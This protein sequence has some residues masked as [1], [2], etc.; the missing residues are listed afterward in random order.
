M[1]LRPRNILLIM[2]WYEQRLHRGVAE[3]AR[4]HRWSLEVSGAHSFWLPEHLNF[5]G[6][7]CLDEA[8]P[9][10][11]KFLVHVQQPTVDLSDWYEGETQRPRVVQDN[12]QIGRLVAE[13]FLE[14]GFQ[15]FAFLRNHDLWHERQRE[16]G[17]A[18][19]LR[20]AGFQAAT[21][22]QQEMR[23]TV[24]ALQRLP[25]PLGLFIPHDFMVPPLLRAL[26]EAKLAI[27]GDIALAGVNNDELICELSP[28]PIS[29]VDPD[30][31]G[32]G[33]QAAAKLEALLQGDPKASGTLR[34]PPLQVV[35][36]T[37]SDLFTVPD[38]RT[39]E[40]LR[41]IHTNSHLN[42]AVEDVAAWVGV[43]RSSLQRLFL[44]H[45]NSSV[46]QQIILAR[47]RQ[48]RRRLA[49]PGTS[50][51]EIARAMNFDSA[52]GLY[53]YLRRHTGESLREHRRRLGQTPQTR[54]GAPP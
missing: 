49:I 50:G 26:L 24:A 1:R 32:Q 30:W 40:A 11:H 6:I 52:D 34:V 35:A 44:R 8:N 45:M 18:A 14:R 36:R 53:M 19:R 46:N 9:A 21:P 27:P 16:A 25:R 51:T 7:I 4:Q 20:E 15:H 48:I 42:L 2:G 43:S 31:S 23:R 17:F 12:E 29:S 38:S 41:Y 5:D 54:T 28:I 39:A 10:L 13:H 37:S 33:W 3:F 47:I 22:R